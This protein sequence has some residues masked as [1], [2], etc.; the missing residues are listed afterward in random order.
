MTIPEPARNEKAL[1]TEGTE[2][3]EVHGV[4]RGFQV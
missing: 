3:I 2:G 1:T 4:H